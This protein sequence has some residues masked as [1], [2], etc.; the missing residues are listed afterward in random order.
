M[1]KKRKTDMQKTQYLIKVLKTH[2]QSI[3]KIRNIGKITPFVIICPSYR[4]FK[5]NKPSRG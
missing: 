4:L 2:L 1:L 3:E 5:K